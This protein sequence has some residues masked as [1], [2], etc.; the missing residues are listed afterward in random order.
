MGWVPCFEKH[1]CNQWTA[2]LSNCAE[3][4]PR[5]CEQIVQGY[6]WQALQR[7]CRERGSHCSIE[8]LEMVRFS[9]SL[10]TGEDNTKK[11]SLNQ[12]LWSGLTLREKKRSSGQLPKMSTWQLRLW[13]LLR[14]SL[15]LLCTPFPVFRG[16]VS[17]VHR[18]PIMTPWCHL[19]NVRLWLKDIPPNLI[20]WIPKQKET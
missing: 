2:T 4:W 19:W 10:L 11:S 9:S 1:K 5:G 3:M 14:L 17:T 13:R 8:V 7:V 12:P 6:L 18:W 15:V 20:I 16:L